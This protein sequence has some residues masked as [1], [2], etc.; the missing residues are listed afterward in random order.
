MTWDFWLPYALVPQYVGAVFNPYAAI[1][2][3]HAHVAKWRQF[4]ELFLS[5]HHILAFCK[6]LFSY[7]QFYNKL[8]YTYATMNLWISYICDAIQGWLPMDVHSRSC[9]MGTFPSLSTMYPVRLAL[10]SYPA[11]HDS[12]SLSTYWTVGSFYCILFLVAWITIYLHFA[13]RRICPPLL[14]NYLS[15]FACFACMG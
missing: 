8:V 5:T 9:S 13:A 1:P 14:V 12:I 15:C 2:A 10:F 11:A 7:T 3:S 4:E 6:H